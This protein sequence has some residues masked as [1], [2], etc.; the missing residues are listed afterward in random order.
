[1]SNQDQEKQI[2]KKEKEKFNNVTSKN[3]VENQNQTHNVVKEAVGPIN[4][5]K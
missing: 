3:K 1:M 5:R 2:Q 4:Q